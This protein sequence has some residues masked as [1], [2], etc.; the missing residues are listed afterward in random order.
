MDHDDERRADRDDR[1][2]DITL[3]DDRDHIG[4]SS[5]C[6]SS[7]GGTKAEPTAS[8]PPDPRLVS[9]VLVTWIELTII[10]ITGGLLGTTI[11]GPPGFI[12]Y[13]ATTLLTVG[14]IFYNVNELVKNWVRT[15]IPD[16]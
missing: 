2:D 9:R 5:D 3:T 4:R 10:G 15:T 14:I 11:G 12:I 7:N 6:D 1:Q 16:R 13:L 8:D